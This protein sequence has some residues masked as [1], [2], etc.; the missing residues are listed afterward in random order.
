MDGGNIKES[1]NIYKHQ[2]DILGDGKV[3][4]ARSMVVVVILVPTI[5][6]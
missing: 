6:E 2:R 3:L 5:Y 4:A 1:D